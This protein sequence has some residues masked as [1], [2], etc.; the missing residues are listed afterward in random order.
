VTVAAFSQ[1]DLYRAVL[2][3]IVQCMLA[4]T[5][6]PLG[7]AVICVYIVLFAINDE[8]FPRSVLAIYWFIVFSYVVASRISVR[9]F[10]R[11]HMSSKPAGDPV[12]AQVT[13][14]AA[15]RFK[16]DTCVPI[17]S[18]KAVR[19]TD[20][21]GASKRI[22]ELIFRAAAARFSP[23]ATFSIMRFGNV[24]GSSGSVIPLEM[25]TKVMR[26]ILSSDCA[27]EAAAIMLRAAGIALPKSEPAT[28]AP[29]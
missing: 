8:E 26:R 24:L 13:A 19:P 7:L 3:F 28:T 6:L 21:M 27:R 11:N 22:A 14:N 25:A 18:D 9:D 16:V 15:E 23:S 4:V 1:S 12:G 5:G 29:S 10:L 17:S 2:R 20:I